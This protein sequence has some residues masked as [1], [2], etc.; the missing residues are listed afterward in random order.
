M[1][2]SS[3]TPLSVTH[4]HLQLHVPTFSQQQL[5]LCV[6]SSSFT[7]PPLMCN[8]APP[9]SLLSF[10]SLINPAP[11]PSICLY[12][13]PLISSSSLTFSS[14]ILPLLRLCLLLFSL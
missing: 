11:Y 8:Y 2:D 6:S 12:L 3:F 14:S 10:V 7:F 13:L 4:L 1:T 9:T 5:L